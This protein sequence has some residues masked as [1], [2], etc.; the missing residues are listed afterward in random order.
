[1]LEADF[2]VRSRTAKRLAVAG[3]LGPM[4]GLGISAANGWWVP[5]WLALGIALANA[6]LTGFVAGVRHVLA[7]PKDR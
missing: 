6:Y 2:T 7:P 1:V 5:M 4:A 3:V